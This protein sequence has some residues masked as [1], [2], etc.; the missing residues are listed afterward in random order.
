MLLKLS[1][2]NEIGSADGIFGKHLNYR[3]SSLRNEILNN[4]WI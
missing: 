4:N 3:D 2:E 1:L